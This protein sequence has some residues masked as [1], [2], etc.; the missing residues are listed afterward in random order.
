MQ[1]TKKQ[2]PS[3]HY[4][5]LLLSTGPKSWQR[6]WRSRNAL[7][8][9]TCHLFSQLEG[10]RALKG[11]GQLL[12]VRNSRAFASR[13]PS[14]GSSPG[15]LSTAGEQVTAKLST[16]FVK[17]LSGWGW[18]LP[19]VPGKCTHPSQSILLT[20]HSYSLELIIIR[21]FLLWSLK[22]F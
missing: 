13:V 20:V 7:H 16:S 19:E 3:L 4:C 1:K 2:N 18:S 21:L 11:E 22:S 6:G 10:L 15:A 8:N 5:Y 12:P 14:T 9:Y 17:G